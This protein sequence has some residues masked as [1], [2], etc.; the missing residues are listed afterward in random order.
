MP[1]ILVVED[2][3]AIRTALAAYLPRHGLEGLL[4]ASG[5][6]ALTLAHQADLVVLDIGLPGI[7]GLEVL[8]RLRVQSPDL[9]VLLLTARSDDLDKIVALELGADDYM[10]KPFNPRELVARIR[11]I[12]RRTGRSEESAPPAALGAGEVVL[13]PA[14]HTV[15]VSGRRVD[16]TP[17][18]FQILQTLMAAP[19]RVFSRD[20]LLTILWG[21]QHVGDPKT[22]DVYIRRLRDKVEAD[23]QQPRLIQT[24]WGIGYKLV[25]EHA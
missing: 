15:Q 2:E 5:E 10:T 23:P 18:E 21:E 6:E 1:R 17:R 22:V 12:L 3:A 16:L 13:D 19:G 9:P 4:A 11:A 14:R 24:V 20:A 8:R 7:D 25:A